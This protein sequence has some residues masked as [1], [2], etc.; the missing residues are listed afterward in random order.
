VATIDARLTACM[1]KPLAPKGIDI[2]SF[3]DEVALAANAVREG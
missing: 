1:L 2:D 3:S